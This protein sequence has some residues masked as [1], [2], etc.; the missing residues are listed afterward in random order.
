MT[1]YVIGVR[2]VGSELFIRDMSVEG[3]IKVHVGIEGVDIK[4][5]R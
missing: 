4:K 1:A 2:L 5:D 3:W